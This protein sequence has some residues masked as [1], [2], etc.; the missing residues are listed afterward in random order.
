MPVG[1]NGSSSGGTGRGRGGATTGVGRVTASVGGT[2]PVA[3]GGAALVG[4]GTCARGCAGCVATAARGLPVREVFR[5]DGGRGGGRPGGFA[6]RFLAGFREIGSVPAGLAALAIMSREREWRIGMFVELKPVLPAPDAGPLPNFG[7]TPGGG[8]GARGWRA[9]F[10][11]ASWPVSS[12]VR[13]NPLGGAGVVC[14]Q[15]DAP[16]NTARAAPIGAAKRNAE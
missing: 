2:T 14:A 12:M 6:V 7:M 5:C 3:S 16:H 9:F 8:A 10:H 15:S 1:P 11:G 13:R 4:C